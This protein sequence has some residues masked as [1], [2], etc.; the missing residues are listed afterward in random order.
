M[1]TFRWNKLLTCF[2]IFWAKQQLMMH[3]F[4]NLSLNF[5]FLFR[6]L[7]M[8]LAHQLTTVGGTAQLARAIGSKIC[9]F[10]F[11]CLLKAHINLNGMQRLYGLMG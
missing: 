11:V 4:Q 8:G 7:S 2:V 9:S 10:H 5:S 3:V 6:S 1:L